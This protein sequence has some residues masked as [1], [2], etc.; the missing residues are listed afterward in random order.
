RQIVIPAVSF[1]GLRAREGSNNNTYYDTCRLIVRKNGSEL[2]N[3]AY[4]G[5]TGLYSGVIDMPAGKGAVT[6][7]FEVQSSA[8]NNWTPSTWISD[9]TVMVTKKATTGI[10]VS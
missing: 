6:L 4:G 3:R 10:T 7:T 2:Y 9:L 1:G 5:N 8:I